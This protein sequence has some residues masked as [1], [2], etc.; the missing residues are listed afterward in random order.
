MGKSLNKM[1]AL[2]NVGKDPE[3]RSTGGGTL[4]ARFSIA[5]SDRRKDAQGN[6]QD[7]TEWINATAFGR[8]AEIVRDY[9]TKGSKVY[10]EGKLQTQQWEKD[11]QKHYKTVVLV[12]ELVLLSGGKESRQDATTGNSRNSA[13]EIDDSEVPF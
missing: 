8:T 12:N 7:Q 10:V 2:G 6:W 9:V 4:V 13:P 5:C 1:L 11:G 3:M